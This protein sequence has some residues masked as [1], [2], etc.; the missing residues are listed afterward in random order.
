MLSSPRVYR[1]A[2]SAEKA[3]GLLFEQAGSA[4]DARVV[5]ALSR[6]LAREP[7]SPLRQA[8]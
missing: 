1:A 3:L 5:E 2:W 7:A 6:V 4:F 8:V